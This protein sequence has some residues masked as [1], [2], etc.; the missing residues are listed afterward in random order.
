MKKLNM[1]NLVKQLNKSHILCVDISDCNSKQ[2]NLKC[3]IIFLSFLF[4]I[5]LLTSNESLLAIINDTASI[6]DFI[7]VAIAWFLTM[8]FQ[9]LSFKMEINSYK[10]ANLKKAPIYAISILLTTIFIW[11]IHFLYVYYN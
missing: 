4:L 10:M 9:P 11:V 1:N 2:Y 6:S 8:G 7:K 5:M 3:E